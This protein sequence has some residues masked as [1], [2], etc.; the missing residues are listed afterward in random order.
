MVLQ[1][2]DALQG[3]G[4]CPCSFAAVVGAE[5]H[6]LEA[7]EGWQDSAAW[8]V[9]AGLC[10]SAPHLSRMG[11]LASLMHFLLIERLPTTMSCI[12]NGMLP[13]KYPS[14]G[15]SPFPAKLPRVF[16]A[17]LSRFLPR[18]SCILRMGEEILV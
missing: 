5:L 12:N 10:S 7:A 15:V 9:L 13:E 2:L 3:G 16:D 8:H 17:L 4:G 18:S 1:P 6:R 11:G 14:I